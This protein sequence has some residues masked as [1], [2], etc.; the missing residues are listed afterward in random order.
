MAA[1]RVKENKVGV[2]HGLTFSHFIYPVN[3]Q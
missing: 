2:D 3:R 1:A